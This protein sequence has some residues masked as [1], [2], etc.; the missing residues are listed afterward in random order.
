MATGVNK[1]LIIGGGFSG[2]TAAIQLSRMGLDV[3]LVEINPE[4]CPIGAGLT[5]SGPTL[6]ALDTIGI[7]DSVATQGYLSQDF[8]VF[9]PNGELVV[10]LPLQKPVSHK[11]IPSGGGILRPA[12]ARI[13]AEATRES[14]TKV[15]LGVTFKQ[16]EEQADS[17]RVVFDD[18]SEGFYGL[19]IGADGVHSRVRSE[20]FPEA[21]GPKPLHQSVWRAVLE[22]PKEITRPSQW[23]GRTKVGVNPISETHMYMFI[24]ESREFGEWIEPAVWPDEMS[25]LLGE[26]PAPVLQGLIS[27]LAKPEANIDYRPLANLLV[28]M[29]WHKGRVVMIGDAVHATTPHLASGAGIGIESAIVL[30][31]ELAR[32]DD[33]PATLTRFE[34]R[35]WERCRLVVENSARLCEIEKN[36][37]DKDEH[38]HIMRDTFI[39]MA[40]PI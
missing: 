20:Y 7:L 33:L 1:I 39:T 26:F 35:R 32:G 5:L 28:P 4:W 10:R 37:G 21:P 9:T 15:R 29:P 6:R 30:A 16:I 14:G 12:L 38:S 31:E 11:E 3:E 34:A 2:M 25:R 27:Q 24:L 23:L 36:G 22:R 18:G 8:D 19:V 13:M 17:V 40:E